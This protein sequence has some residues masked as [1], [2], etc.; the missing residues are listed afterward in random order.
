MSSN[1][2]KTILVFKMSSALRSDFNDS[3][4]HIFHII[5]CL[6]HLL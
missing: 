2:E 6:L 4:W 3:M 1:E 5:D